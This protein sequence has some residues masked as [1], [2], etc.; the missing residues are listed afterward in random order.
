MGG[1][2]FG[3]A[4]ANIVA[5]NGH[6]V[7]LWLRNSERAEEINTQHLNSEY[8]PDFPLH[9]ALHATV[10]LAEA[11]ADCDFIFMAV[12]S[13]SCRAVAKE[14]ARHILPRSILISTT[15]GI[16][17]TDD[18][19][20]FR[21]MS[22]V[23]RDEIADVRF[24]VISGPNLAKEIAA[25][26]ITATVI[27]SDDADVN[28]Q[29]QALLS[30]RYFRVYDSADMRGVE[31]GGALKNVYAIIAGMAAALGIGHNTISMLITRALA[32]MTRFAV[33]KGADPLTFMGL[34]GIGDLMVTCMSPLSRNYQVGFALGKGKKL[35]ETIAELGQVAEGINT[36]KLLK[37]HAEVIDVRMPL[38]A[39]LYEILYNGR[40][41]PDVVGKLMLA[42]QNRDVE[43]SLR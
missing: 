9:V 40:S 23:L 2:S 16:E 17:A 6:A 31:L 42:E 7:T 12:P 36:L 13:S 11:V 8:L 43:Y 30:C 21:M 39:G 25:K 18:A 22:D 37:I 10:D 3:T 26:Q 38:V 34:A 14:L 35:E 4:L 33:R 32:E 27:A 20:S 1:G 19:T 29:V 28:L 15:K 41:I 5:E 24:G